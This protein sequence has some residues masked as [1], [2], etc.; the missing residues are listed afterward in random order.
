MWHENIDLDSQSV[1]IVFYLNE[2]VKNVLI[3][4]IVSKLGFS[5]SFSVAS[6]R[7][8][9]YNSKLACQIAKILNIE[10]FDIGLQ[11]TTG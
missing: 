11:L 4:L 3:N 8:Y 7:H 5:N 1:Q 10:R 6:W 9:L 2:V